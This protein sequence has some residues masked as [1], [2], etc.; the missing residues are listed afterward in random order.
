MAAEDGTLVQ[1]RGISTHGLGWFPDYVNDAM[2]AQARQEWGCNVFRLAMYT[3]EYNGY[4]TSDEK[5]K[6][7]LKNLIDT[8]VLFAEKHYFCIKPLRRS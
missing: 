5:Q 8:G 3:A 1:L 7:N 6:Q 2:I 4:C